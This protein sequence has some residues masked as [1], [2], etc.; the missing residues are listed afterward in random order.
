MSCQ[1]LVLIAAAAL[2]ASVASADSSS[3]SG[4]AKPAAD[5][6]KAC[7][8]CDQPSAAKEDA[9]PHCGDAKPKHEDCECKKGAHGGHGK[10]GDHGK[11]GGHGKQSE[12]AG[13]GSHGGHASHGGM[14]SM[15]G[16]LG[17][18]AMTREASG[19]S[20][21]PDATPHHMGH[22]MWGDWAI[23]AHANLNL[24]YDWQDGPRGDEKTFVSGMAMVS[25]RRS[26][27]DDVL[28]LRLMLSPDALMGKSGYP[29]LLAAGETA[30]GVNHLVDRQHPHDLFMELS[31]SYSFALGDGEA[32]FLYAGLPGEPAFG[33]P[34]FMHRL[35]A[36]QSPEAPISHHW[37]DSTHIAF[38]V[39][40]AGWVKDAWK[41]E[42]SAFKGREPDEHRFD[43]ES[44][45][46]DSVAARVSFN[47]TQ[48]WSL[49][50]SW[51]DQKSVEQLEPLV[52]E[53]KLSASA[54]YTVALSDEGW[55]STTLAWGWKDP[56][57]GDTTNAFA[58]ES[59]Y[60]PNRDWT[61]FARG[62]ITENP[63][64]GPDTE[65]VGKISFGAVRDFQVAN[66]TAL[67]IGA[68]YSVNF[69]PDALEPS[70]GGNPDGAMIFIRLTTSN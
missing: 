27:G 48:N 50:I 37:L 19:T 8:H 57:E 22:D 35:S 69:I 28:N 5:K 51:A 9:C 56:S 12:H 23:S 67:G 16:V 11:H 3:H 65:T 21:Q 29:L 70:Y 13:H 40:T 63:E 30:D 53:T 47:P 46:L 1:Y 38:G 14:T 32:L 36:M 24:V 58:L 44:P 49:Q 60:A 68:L 45:K 15:T 64:L 43:I 59:A 61:L 17:P 66:N 33:P 20:W 2:S 25:A 4:H 18:Y 52:D 34:A 7:P 42:V 31:A 54:I 10:H 26:F 41:L 39:L 62:E 6:E 55:W